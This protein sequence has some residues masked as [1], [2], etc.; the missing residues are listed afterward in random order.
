[1]FWLK[2]ARAAVRL[3]FPPAVQYLE[4]RQCACP[5]ALNQLSAYSEPIEVSGS[6]VQGPR[7]GTRYARSRTYWRGLTAGAA[8]PDRKG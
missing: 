4:I 2:L 3:G 6:I 1:M 5:C 8:D 7:G